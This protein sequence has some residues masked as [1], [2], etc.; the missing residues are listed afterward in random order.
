MENHKCRTIF[1]PHLLCPPSLNLWQLQKF[2]K[3]KNNHMKSPLFSRFQKSLIL[4]QKVCENSWWFLENLWMSQTLTQDLILKIFE[5]QGSSSENQVSRDSQLT[6]D[7]YCT[8]WEIFCWLENM[9]AISKPLFPTTICIRKGCARNMEIELPVDTDWNQ[10]GHHWQRVA[11]D[12]IIDF[13]PN[14]KLLLLQLLKVNSLFLFGTVN[15]KY[16]SN[17]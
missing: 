9:S 14:W 15:R 12:N 17:K 10:H 13:Y 16:W 1:Q 11:N 7:Q 5:Y 3:W 2:Q 8:R 6:L 4:C